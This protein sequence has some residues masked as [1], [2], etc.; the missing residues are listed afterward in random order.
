MMAQ[1]A[2]PTM[3]LEVRHILVLEALATQGRVGLAIQVRVE[4]AEV[5]RQ[6]GDEFLAFRR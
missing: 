2:H 3:D 1:A 5:A 6:F 4:Q